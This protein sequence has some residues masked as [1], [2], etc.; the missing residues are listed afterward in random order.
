MST[1]S[2]LEF[3]KTLVLHLVDAS[4]GQPAA[5]IAVSLTLHARRKNDY[6]FAPSLSDTRGMITVE[7]D[8]V[9]T[10]IE[11][12]RNF[13]LMDYQSNMDDCL[14]LVDLRVMSNEDLDR[15]AA[16]SRIY[17]GVKERMGVM[18][19]TEDLENASNR[20]YRPTEIQLMLEVPGVDVR[21]E[22][23]DLQRAEA[24]S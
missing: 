20:A 18:L 4:T 1:T 3:P 7:R 9:R 19:T 14:P 12:T 2:R 16:A 17:K 11:E 13:F 21:E 10:S 23:V 22:T 24:P 6:H 8:W 5:D 15:A